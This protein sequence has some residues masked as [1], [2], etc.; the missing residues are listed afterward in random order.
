MKVL[1]A[2]VLVI[3]FGTGC[4]SVQQASSE[5][6]AAV[7]T[8][9][10]VPDKGTLYIYRKPV[11]MWARG[12]TAP[13]TVDGVMIAALRPGHFIVVHVV[14]GQHAITSATMDTRRVQV[15]AG[16]NYFIRERQTVT[17]AW[18][19]IVH[20]SEGKID[21]KNCQLLVNLGDEANLKPTG[22]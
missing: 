22:N 16:K 4:A 12:Q 13:I 5:Q 2:L 11:V 18:I 17:G 3:C 9:A 7:K 6:E 1:S 10:T 8:F 14:P 20:E 19:E 15:E 21:V